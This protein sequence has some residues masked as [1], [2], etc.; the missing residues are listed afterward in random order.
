MLNSIPSGF[1]RYSPYFMNNV[2]NKTNIN[3]VNKF[4]N[5]FNFDLEETKYPLMFYVQNINE[6]DCYL[7]IEQLFNREKINYYVKR[8]PMD[9]VLIDMDKL[10]Y[11]NETNYN[12]YRNTLLTRIEYKRKEYNVLMEKGNITDMYMTRILQRI[13]HS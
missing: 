13:M 3:K 11:L 4:L 10:V 12:M 2:T 6:Y 8:Y 1:I 7:A 5:L 9:K